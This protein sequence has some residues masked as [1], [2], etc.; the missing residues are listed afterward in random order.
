MNALVNTDE[1]H[2]PRIIKPGDSY[3]EGSPNDTAGG[4]GQDRY[5]LD[6]AGPEARE[7]AGL[8]LEAA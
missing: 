5:C 1:R 6:C 7:A 2:M 4:F 3:A 8:K